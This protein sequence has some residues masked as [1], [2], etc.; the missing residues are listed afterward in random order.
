MKK[1]LTIKL[2]FVLLIVVIITTSLIGTTLAKYVTTGDIATETA[3][4]AKWGVTVTATNVDTMFSTEYY[5]VDNTISNFTATGTYDADEMSVRSSNTEKVVAPGTNGK[6]GAYSLAG[7][8]EVDVIVNYAATLE[9]GD[10]WTYNSAYYCP[11]VITVNGTAISGLTYTSADDFEDAVVATINGYTKSYEAGTDLANVGTDNIGITWAWA[12]ESGYVCNTAGT[13]NT[14]AYTVG[15]L[16]DATTYAALTDPDKANFTNLDVYDTALG[17][18]A[19]A[20]TNVPCITF[21][22]DITVTQVD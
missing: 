4:V 9:L 8:P 13:Y 19:A 18:A 3:R 6:L 14:V 5:D 16:I 15:Q 11:I 21:N 20:G 1:N 10:N 12:F 7:N 17:N 2:T 22:L